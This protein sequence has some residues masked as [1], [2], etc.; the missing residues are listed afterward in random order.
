[1]PRSCSVCTHEQGWQIDLDLVRRVSY[2][3]IAERF[4]VSQAALSRHARE[5]LPAKLLAS[6]DAEDV[7]DADLIKRQL[8]NEKADISRLKSKAEDGGDYRTALQACDKALKALELQARLAQLI[9][10]APTLNLYLST[11]WLELRAVIVSALEP[12]PGARESVLRALEGTGSG[13]A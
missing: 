3:K 7:A 13:R 12:Y 5:H 2:R 8:E 1:M 10:E 6:Q 4:G 9:N 11:E